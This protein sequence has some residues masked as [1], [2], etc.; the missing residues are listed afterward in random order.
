MFWEIKHKVLSSQLTEILPMGVNKLLAGLST[1]FDVQGSSLNTSPAGDPVVE[2]DR[3]TVKDWFRFTL[4]SQECPYQRAA[5]WVSPT[6]KDVRARM[7]MADIDESF[8]DCFTW[9]LQERNILQKHF[10]SA[11][12]PIALQTDYWVEFVPGLPKQYPGRN[13]TLDVATAEPLLTTITE[14]R[15]IV[16][17]GMQPCCLLL[18]QR[19]QI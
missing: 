7:F 17:R 5:T 6:T 14:K 11:D 12:V 15:G 10:R 8:I 2:P 18:T 13:M 3:I 19:M 4:P 16:I 9:V 1:I